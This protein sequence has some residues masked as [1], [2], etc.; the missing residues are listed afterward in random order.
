MRINIHV[1]GP[2]LLGGAQKLRGVDVRT[3]DELI[4][5]LE[6]E[7]RP[8]CS[9]GVV[10]ID[11]LRYFDPEFG[12]YVL[13]EDL[14]DL[15]PERAKLE[16]VPPAGS[17]A[18]SAASVPTHT[19]TPPTKGI[20]RQVHRV[21]NSPTQPPL[22][23]VAVA[24]AEREARRLREERCALRHEND[25]L[26]RELDHS[27]EVRLHI[28]RT[29]AAFVQMTTALV[30]ASANGG[31]AEAQRAI[32]LFRRITP[33]HPL[34]GQLRDKDAA[35]ADDLIRRIMDVPAPQALLRLT[36]A[37]GDTLSDVLTVLTA[38]AKTAARA[39]HDATLLS[40]ERAA[41]AKASLSQEEPPVRW[42]SV[43]APNARHVAS[44]LHVENPSPSPS[45]P[46]PRDERMVHVFVTD[47]KRIKVVSIDAAGKDP[48]GS[49]TV[50][51]AAKLDGTARGGLRFAYC[52]DEG[53][54]W[55]V[56]DDDSFLEFLSRFPPGLNGDRRKAQL[57]CYRTTVGASYTTPKPEYDLRE[58]WG[59]HLHES[60]VPDEQWRA[61]WTEYLGRYDVG[62]T[63]TLQQKEL[64]A[65]LK[66]E[67]SLGWLDDASLDP[68]GRKVGGGFLE[69]KVRSILLQL[70]PRHD[71]AITYD[72][73]CLIMLKLTQV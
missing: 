15:P 66:Q 73:F 61:K 5:L 34:F 69:A 1:R 72:E 57:N 70:D 71:G 8:Q 31:E 64:C 27:E 14:T 51:L 50:Q 13:L 46:P 3:V 48:F 43:S 65:L 68:S 22:S 11:T 7:L 29:I 59:D 47:L 4:T 58:A 28:V 24:D 32:D 44:D 35:T 6:R 23:A 21:R 40:Y 67:V 38:A 30:G 39:E 36:S 45:S 41:L 60:L 16:L 17:V 55:E 54:S 26:R 33:S 2:G 25:M 42:A 49:L 37:L 56:D 63:G 62:C 18:T 52:D 53:Y 19:L 20:H 12:D 10:L 9:G